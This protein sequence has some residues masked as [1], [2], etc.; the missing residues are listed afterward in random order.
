MRS[1]NKGPGYL[2]WLIAAAIGVVVIVGA[3][4][5]D[6]PER[7]ADDA[8]T[9]SDRTSD[10]DG[11]RKMGGDR[12]R[13]RD[14]KRGAASDRDGDRDRSDRDEPAERET[15]AGIPAEAKR[16]NVTAVTDGDTVD[17]AGLGAARLIGIDTP[18]TYSGA[19]CFGG[20][21]TAFTGRWLAP[22]TPV[23]YVRGVEP[24]DQYGR[25]LV[26]IW[27]PGGTFFNALLA[28]EGYAVP[29]TIAPNVE[30]AELFRRLSAEARANDRG[31]WALST[32]DG[33]PDRPLA[34]AAGSSGGG[35]GGAGAAARGT[36]GAGA[37]GGS[38]GSGCE[39]GYDPCVPRY[40]PDVDCADVDGP[41]S[42]SGSDPHGLDEDRDGVG[43][44]A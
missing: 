33:N 2:G 9:V 21:A 7:A 11:N 38:L 20:R 26:Y 17:L 28:K 43:C 14:R 22:G 13:S 23:Y 1:R 32:C 8:P 37:G 19:E 4:S 36:A 16:T 29:L 27:L 24:V 6:S 39:P 41:I 31:L 44:E 40:P 25:D 34:A 35:S 3:V 12:D 5:D 30:H 42:V 10:A 18:E 15:P